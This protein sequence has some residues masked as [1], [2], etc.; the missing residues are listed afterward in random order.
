M[1]DIQKMYQAEDGKI[2]IP[3]LSNRARFRYVLYVTLLA[4]GLL[5]LVTELYEYP[6]VLLFVGVLVIS[7]RRLYMLPADF[8]PIVISLN[9]DMVQVNKKGFPAEEILFLSFRQIEDYRIVRL[10]ARRKHILFAREAILKTNC[11]GV[12]EALAF[13]RSIRDFIDPELKINHM[14]LVSGKS[15]DTG[16]GSKSIK[17]EHWEFVQ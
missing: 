12:E 4:L 5:I 2:I 9:E 10:E 1:N 7:F 11:S 16:Q 15:E 17:F 3:G 13:C 14:R 6:V 8:R